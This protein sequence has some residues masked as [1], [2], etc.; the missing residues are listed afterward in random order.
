MTNLMHKALTATRLLP[1]AFLA[2]VAALLVTDLVAFWGWNLRPVA[3]VDAIEIAVWAIL[4]GTALTAGIRWTVLN[5]ATLRFQAAA[6]VALMVAFSAL[7]PWHNG[8][9]AS[10]DSPAVPV[11]TRVTPSSVVV[12]FENGPL[13]QGEEQKY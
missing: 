11:E 8:Y 10:A 2:C 5:D 13:T 7:H 4:G 9:A 1:A 3:S 12:R 6:A